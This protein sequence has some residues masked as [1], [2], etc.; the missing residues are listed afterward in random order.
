MKIRQPRKLDLLAVGISVILAIFLILLM[1]NLFMGIRKER[2]EEG[3]SSIVWLINNRCD[4]E[5]YFITDAR[6][7]FDKRVERLLL[8]FNQLDSSPYIFSAVYDHDLNILSERQP[9][10]PNFPFHP[11]DYEEINI[12]I[13]IDPR[14]ILTVPYTVDKV[15]YSMNFYFR[16]VSLTADDFVY[17]AIGVPY[18][19]SDINVASNL[20]YLVLFI[21]LAAAI[22]GI[23]VYLILFLNSLRPRYVRLL[24]PGEKE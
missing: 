15:V 17:V 19:P 10:F 3:W 7:D 14:G 6:S 18:I 22:S 11:F 13:C 24:K 9:R 8:F 5:E 1:D 21:S 23:T 4:E 12:C 2:Y 16:K 20:T